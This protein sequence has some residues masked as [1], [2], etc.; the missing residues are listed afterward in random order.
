MRMGHTECIAEA[1]NLN[2]VLVEN[3]KGISHFGSVDLM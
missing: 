3:F 2:T 1:R